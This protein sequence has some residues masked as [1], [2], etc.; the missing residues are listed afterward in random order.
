MALCQQFSSYA[1]LILLTLPICFFYRLLFNEADQNQE[2]A[3]H[4][5]VFRGELSPI[6]VDKS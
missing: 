3:V 1:V 5:R 2:L 4:R 6:S